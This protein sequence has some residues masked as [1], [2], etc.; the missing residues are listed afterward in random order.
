MEHGIPLR[1]P[2]S[3]AVVIHST[4]IYKTL[5]MCHVHAPHTGTDQ[6]PK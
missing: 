2:T 5:V 1:C 3:Q 4:N 6:V